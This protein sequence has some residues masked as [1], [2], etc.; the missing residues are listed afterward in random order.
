MSAEDQWEGLIAPRKFSTLIHQL[1]S[2]LGGGERTVIR[3]LLRGANP[4]TTCHKRC[5]KS[6]EPDFIRSCMRHLRYQKAWHEGPGSYRSAV[7]KIPKE[8][9]TIGKDKVWY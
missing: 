5:G 2:K 4:D 9:L 1:L 3:R 6:V 7:S 8:S